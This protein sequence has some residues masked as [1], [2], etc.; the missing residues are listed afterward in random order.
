[1]HGILIT[2]STKRLAQLEEDP[3]TLEDVLDARHE[4][5]IP[6]LLDIGKAWDALDVM[7][8][9]RGKDALLGGRRARPQRP[10]TR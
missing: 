4:Q 7:L 5:P 2:L 8:S 1:M 3:E 9:D 6:G 10:T